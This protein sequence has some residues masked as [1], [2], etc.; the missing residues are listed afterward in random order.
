VSAASPES[1]VRVSLI[2]TVLNEAASI[3]AWLDTLLRQTRPPDEIVIVDAGS[4]DGT[5]DALQ[6]AAGRSATPMRVVVAPG[7]NISQGRNRAISE[8]R[9]HIIA[10]SD[11]GTVLA[12]DWLERLLQPL[13]DPEVDVAGGFYQ[14]AGRNHFE[15][16]LARIITPRLAEIDP[17]TFLPSSRSVAFRRRA[18]ERA[19]GYPEWLP[20][21]E[22]VVF[23]MR[24]RAAGARFALAPDAIVS[25][26]PAPTPR[27]YFRQWKRYAR[28]D[29]HARL[30][31][32]RHAIRYSAY[33]SGVALVS[34]GR[35]RR[36]PRVVLALGAAVYLRKFARRLWEN[37]P[38]DSA[39]GMAAATS[40]IPAVVVG[41]D[42]AKMIGYPLGRWE[43]W[44][45]GGPAGLAHSPAAS[46]RT[47][48][49]LDDAGWLTRDQVTVL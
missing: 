45:A 39:R 3:D 32:R 33:L 10:A 29:G 22:D 44:R 24:L 14:P 4:E 5:L 23:D 47:L 46:H 36:S 9:G 48:D 19:G 7:A 41:G 18:W 28:G 17:E 11:A 27:A 16:A 40:L 43:R 35:T 20:I 8:A 2:A 13:A 12:R 15:R 25:W 30:F 42:V 31:G 26:F 38:F 1:S 49:E 6:R 37:R 21:C 34:L